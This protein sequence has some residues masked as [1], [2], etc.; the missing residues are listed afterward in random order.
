M[1]MGSPQ[2]DELIHDGEPIA[3]DIE[4]ES[5]IWSDDR[6]LLAAQRLVYG[7]EAPGTRIVVFGAPN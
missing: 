4:H 5:L 1:R 2:Y 7:K 6:R 3:D